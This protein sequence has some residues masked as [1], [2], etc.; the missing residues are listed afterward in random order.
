MSKLST[1]SKIQILKQR[2]KFSRISV[3]ESS[4]LFPDMLDISK[5]FLDMLD[6][7]KT[8]KKSIENHQKD[9][10]GHGYWDQ[11]VK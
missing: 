4:N 7:T 3:V 5:L 9:G 10:G 2:N 11:R 1:I 6:V 8:K